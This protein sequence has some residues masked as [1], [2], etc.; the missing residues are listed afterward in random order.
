MRLDE[1]T[2]FL[3]FLGVRA[4]APQHCDRLEQTLIKFFHAE[5]QRGGEIIRKLWRRRSS[6]LIVAN[7]NLFRRFQLHREANQC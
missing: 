5:A 1:I 7:L 3:R 4:F 2:L 6:F